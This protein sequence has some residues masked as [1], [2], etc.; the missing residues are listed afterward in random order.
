MIQVLSQTQFTSNELKEL[1]ILVLSTIDKKKHMLENYQECKER[2]KEDKY[3][4]YIAD[5]E[6]DLI[7]LESIAQKFQ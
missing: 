5:I 4:M 1:R 3:E 7:V 6:K 2:F